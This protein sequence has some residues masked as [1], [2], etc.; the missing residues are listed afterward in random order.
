LMTLSFAF[1]SIIV[2]VQAT[3]PKVFLNN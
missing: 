2:L 1:G 3:F